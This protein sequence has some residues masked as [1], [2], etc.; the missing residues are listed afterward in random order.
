[1]K[2]LQETATMMCSDD[3]KERFAAEYHQLRI[4]I[5]KLVAMTKKW[6][7]CELDF[8]PQCPRSIYNLQLRAMCDY[9][10]VLELRAK[11]E[12]INL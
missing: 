6:D 2:E 4:R 8:T 12:G 7:R 11:V 9:M 1:M 10:A 3:Y 5:D